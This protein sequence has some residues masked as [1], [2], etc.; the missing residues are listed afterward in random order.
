MH[1]L[2]VLNLAQN[3]VLRRR[4]RIAIN[5][6]SRFDKALLRDLNIEEKDI[7]AVIDASL[8]RRVADSPECLS[9]NKPV[10]PL[11]RPKGKRYASSRT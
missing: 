6:L 3:F 7:E 1:I 11:I 5:E 9:R 10:T 2:S 8:R 4:R